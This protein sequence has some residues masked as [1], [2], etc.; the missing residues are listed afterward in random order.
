ML[1]LIQP[2]C[3]RYNIWWRHNIQRHTKRAHAY[4]SPVVSWIPGLHDLDTG[5]LLDDYWTLVDTIWGPILTGNWPPRNT[6]LS[7]SWCVLAI[8]GLPVTGSR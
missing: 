3:V 5:V 7:D 1:N 2:G 6:K 8:I 4:A